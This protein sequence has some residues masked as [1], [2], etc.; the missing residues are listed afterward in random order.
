MNVIIDPTDN[1]GYSITSEIGRNILKNYLTNYKNG[2]EWR[3]PVP[4]TVSCSSNSENGFVLCS[5]DPNFAPRPV[6]KR[7][8]RP[9]PPSRPPPPLPAKYVKNSGK[10][11]FFSR[12]QN[13]R[14]PTYETS[15]PIPPSTHGVRG[16]FNQVVMT[17][18]PGPPD[19]F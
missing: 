9:G 17:R 13:A 19:I 12:R 10:G 18:P 4:I 16:K 1:M 2:G 8:K 6:T 15:K 7:P 14:K 11:D 5:S 3:K